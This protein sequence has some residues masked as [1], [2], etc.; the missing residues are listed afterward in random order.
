MRYNEPNS[1]KLGGYVD[2]KTAAVILGVDPRTLKKAIERYEIPALRFGRTYRIP[3][4]ALMP[5]W[6]PKVG[7]F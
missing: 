7:G 3:L 2:L 4:A 5:E 1:L 6:P